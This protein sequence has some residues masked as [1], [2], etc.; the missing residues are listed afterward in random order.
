LRKLDAAVADIHC[1]VGRLDGKEFL[2]IGCGSGLSSLAAYRLGASSITSIDIDP[3]NIENTRRLKVKFGVPVHY[4]WTVQVGSIVA[5]DDVRVLQPSDVVYAW[6][7]LHHTGAMWKA[8][9]NAASLVK[10]DGFLY[11]MIYRDAWLAPF[12]KAIKRTYVKAPG[13]VK[14]LM[15]NAFAGLQIIG[16]LAKHLSPRKVRARIRDYGVSNRGMSWY[17]D[18][19][20]WIGG[21]P[22]EYAEAEAVIAA[23][24]RS[25]FALVK[26][27]PAITPKALGVR[28]TGS[29]QYLFKKTVV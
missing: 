26:I 9:A 23:L 3:V 25:G 20:D 14:F 5:A 15:R 19:T 10:P 1:F 16:M 18:L 6:G 11:L 4:P 17:V 7:V 13:F 28:G 22:F 27:L 8:I 12:W 21:Y 24:E 2:D 29:Y